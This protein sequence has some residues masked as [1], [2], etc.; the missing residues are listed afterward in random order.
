MVFPQPFGKVDPG[1][2]GSVIHVKRL[3][4]H[5]DSILRTLGMRSRTSG[6]V[7]AK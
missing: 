7:R 5:H 3:D 4:E 2:V 1:Q 6:D